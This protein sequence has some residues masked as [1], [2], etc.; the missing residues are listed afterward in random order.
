MGNQR[1]PLADLETEPRFIIFSMGKH[2]KFHKIDLKTF[3]TKSNS[4]W[5]QPKV[6]F[7]Y[8]IRLKHFI[9]L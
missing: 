7:M 3:G 6:Y 1:L 8:K 9:V 5:R 2:S 4:S